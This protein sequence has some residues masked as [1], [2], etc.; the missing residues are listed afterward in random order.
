MTNTARAFAVA[1]AVVVAVVGAL[2]YRH[3]HR[4]VHL[5]EGDHL[6]PIRLE[7]LDGSAYTLDAARR[8]Q[9]INVFATWCPPCRMETP[10]FAA[11]ARKLQQRGVAV[12]GIDQQETP[13]AVNAFARE[14]S[15]T[16]PVYVDSAGITRYVL[17]ARVIPTTIYVDATGVIRWE[18][19]G[20]LSAQDLVQLARAW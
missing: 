14:F 20:P 5:K 10:G 16:Y 2:T 3:E 8:P 11:L 4:I 19:V 13:D 6:V 18:H 12:V 7:A 17:G 1:L 9:I 15:L